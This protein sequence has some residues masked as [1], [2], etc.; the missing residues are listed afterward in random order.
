MLQFDAA[1]FRAVVT[2]PVVQ[3]AVGDVSQLLQPGSVL[4]EPDIQERIAAASAR[5]LA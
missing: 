1:L 5:A 3:R 2:D 4:Q